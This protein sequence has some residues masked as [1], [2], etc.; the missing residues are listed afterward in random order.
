M[1]GIKAQFQYKESNLIWHADALVYTDKIVTIIDKR[2]W[3]VADYKW[4]HNESELNTGQSWVYQKIGLLSQMHWTVMLLLLPPSP[5]LLQEKKLSKV[6]E[7]IN[8]YYEW[9]HMVKIPFPTICNLISRDLF[10]AKKKFEIY[11]Q[12][13]KHV[14]NDSLRYTENMYT[15]QEKWCLPF[16]E[17]EC[18]FFFLYPN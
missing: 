4:L 6:F 8:E 5:L 2:N 1:K 18:S 14:R 9:F 15:E 12:K 10:A 16:L 13:G 7:C 3:N 17:V 11:E